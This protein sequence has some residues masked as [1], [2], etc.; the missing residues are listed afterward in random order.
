MYILKVF[1][2]FFPYSCCTLGSLKRLM[3][4]IIPPL[5][6]IRQWTWFLISSIPK[7]LFKAYLKAFFCRLFYRQG[8]PCCQVFQMIVSW[9]TVRLE[10]REPHNEN[11]CINQRKLWSRSQNFFESF[12]GTINWSIRAWSF[13]P[14]PASVKKDYC[15]F[16]VGKSSSLTSW[17]MSWP[18][19]CQENKF[20]KVF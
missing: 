7:C 20:D 6:W 4:G 14:L 17:T 11:C 8:L 12:N 18:Y 19:G 16:N 3:F 10:R 5:I 9:C 1:S 13:F 2:F 15:C